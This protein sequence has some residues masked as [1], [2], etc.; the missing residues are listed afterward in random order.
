MVFFQLIS[1]LHMTPCLFVFCWHSLKQSIISSQ[2]YLIR[3]NGAIDEIVFAPDAASLPVYV[4]LL[5]MS[6]CFK[7]FVC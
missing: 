6:L 5:Q 7:Y 1:L 2:V 4:H 3:A